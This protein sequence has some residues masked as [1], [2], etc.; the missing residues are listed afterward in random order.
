VKKFSSHLLIG[1]LLIII[2]ALLWSIDSTFLRPHL[3]TLPST[4]VVFLEH[5]LGFIPLI[6]FL[7]VYR[8]E[9][10]KITKKQWLAIFWVAL[11]GGA[12]GTTFF[13]KAL[14]LTGFTDISA[15]I[16]LQKF[17][18]L[19]AIVLAALF[20]HERFPP[21]FYLLSTLAL[22]GGYF[23]TFPNP[24]TIST[25]SHTSLLIIAYALLAAFAWGSATVFGKYSLKTIPFGLLTAL[26]FG[27][28][29]LIMVIPASRYFSTISTIHGMQWGI[30]GLI[31]V[32]SGAFS[33]YIY[34]S[35]L[36]RIPA[37]L[38]TLCELAWPVS[39]V[40]FDYVINHTQ[41]T[42]LQLLGTVVLLGTI[43]YCT[44]LMRA[45]T[46]IGIVH[47]GH[48][49]GEKTGA[50]T[51]NLDLALAKKLPRG[52]YTCRVTWEHESRSGLLYYGINSLTNE[53]CLEVHLLDFN[54]DLYEKEIT[55]QT[56]RFLRIPKRF[57][58][59]EALVEQIK[60]DIRFATQ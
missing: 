27:V 4:L 30:F 45:R 56:E 28:T 38:A 22:I 59:T 20:L 40:V 10:K 57:A 6:P 42:V 36:K 15:V 21:R 19:F 52:L 58:T 26:R 60:K 49:L 39:A 33:I 29:M 50:K 32:T 8:K 7:F 51:A 48:K 18:P 11:F 55:V 41:L 17:Q 23:M 24:F 25:L 34:Y 35:G 5:T 54:A 43:T 3:Q 1:S 2:A 47:H 13:T 9:L 46:L 53:I 37:S 12:L 16:L 14:F 44:W 31:V